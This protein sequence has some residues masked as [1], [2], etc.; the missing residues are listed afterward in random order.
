MIALK[1]ATSERSKGAIHLIDG[2]ILDSIDTVIFA[3]GYNNS[4]PFCKVDDLPWRSQALLDEV[5]T[6]EE[7]VGGDVWE[8]GGLRGLRMRGMD[9]LQLFMQNDR[10][11]AFLGLREYTPEPGQRDEV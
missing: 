10:S 7:R 8:V 9:E 4:L 2:Q 3:T 5:I 1:N 6:A 11:I